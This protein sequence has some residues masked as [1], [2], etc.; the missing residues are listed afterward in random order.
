M[1]VLATIVP[2]GNH[3]SPYIGSLRVFMLHKTIRFLP[4]T[5]NP[6]RKATVA[7][8]P[9]DKH[10]YIGTNKVKKLFLFQ[11]YPLKPILN[12]RQNQWSNNKNWKN[13]ISS[14][15]FGVLGALSS[16]TL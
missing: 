16:R 12:E 1:K 10:F 9:G 7:I 2:R 11:I 5:C 8:A 14:W 13:E 3:L 15:L 6:V 4:L